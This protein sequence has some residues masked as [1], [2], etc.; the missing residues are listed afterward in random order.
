M[1]EPSLWNEPPLSRSEPSYGMNLP[2]R[3]VNLLNVSL[4]EFHGSLYNTPP[5]GD[6]SRGGL[7][8]IMDVHI[9][10]RAAGT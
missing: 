7:S 4:H 5:S 10:Q 8:Y 1:S 6:R 3:G 2:S 9:P